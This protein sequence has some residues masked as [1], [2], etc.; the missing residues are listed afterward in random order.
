MSVAEYI[1]AHGLQ[2]KVEQILNL[3]VKNKPA[4][5]MSFMVSAGRVGGGYTLWTRLGSIS[6]L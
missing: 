3:C 6:P 4:E 2:E 5:P 1:E